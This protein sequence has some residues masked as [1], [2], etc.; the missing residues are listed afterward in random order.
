MS[1]ELDETE[2]EVISRK[3]LGPLAPWRLTIAVAT[4]AVFTGMPLFD[5][6]TAG[7][8]VDMAL[9]RSFGVAFLTWVAVGALNRA[10]FD[11][12]PAA[13]RANDSAQEIHQ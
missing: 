3:G 12:P 11:I 5:A 10:L 2:D 1:D 4:S 7:V 8:G 13:G 9:L 6:A